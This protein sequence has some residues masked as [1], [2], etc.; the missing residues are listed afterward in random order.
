MIRKVFLFLFVS[1]L[2]PYSKSNGMQLLNDS[3]SD[4]EEMGFSNKVKRVFIDKQYPQ[5]YTFNEQ[6]DLI[7]GISQVQSNYWYDY[8]TYNSGLLIEKIKLWT[9][10]QYIKYEYNKQKQLIKKSIYQTV[11]NF[12]FDSCGIMRAE[13]DSSKLNLN[14][15]INEGKLK[16]REIRTYNYNN[17]GKLIREEHKS[18]RFNPMSR[19]AMYGIPRNKTIRYLYCENGQLKKKIEKAPH[20]RVWKIIETYKYNHSQLIVLKKRKLIRR[21]YNFLFNR[22]FTSI[23]YSYDSNKRLVKKCSHNE[24]K[25]HKSLWTREYIYNSDNQLSEEWSYDIYKPKYKEV[26]VKGNIK[27]CNKYHYNILGDIEKVIPFRISLK[28]NVTIPSSFFDINSSYF[29]TKELTGSDDKYIY[30]YF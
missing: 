24:D 11:P 22:E 2:L 20:S 28:E 21:W 29:N 26:E 17:A 1:L 16:L 13:N 7:K 18:V 9:Y 5:E 25:Y 23:F 12:F 14:Q 30:E 27:W 15:R 10:R 3:I 4:R 8:N 6:G 19:A